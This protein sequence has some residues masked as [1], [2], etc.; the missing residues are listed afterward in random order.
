MLKGN[1]TGSCVS[2]AG[3][4]NPSLNTRQAVGQ[5]PSSMNNREEHATKP[6]MHF[7]MKSI[8]YKT[9]WN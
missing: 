8:S 4:F 9:G 7:P 3:G 1:L 2:R 6:Y 5:A